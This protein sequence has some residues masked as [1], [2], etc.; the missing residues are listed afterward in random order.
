V[1]NTHRA[2]LPAGVEELA[3][4]TLV[5]NAV[6]ESEVSVDVDEAQLE[7]R[8]LE[9]E[10]QGKLAAVAL[11]KLTLSS[12]NLERGREVRTAFENA[13]PDADVAERLLEELTASE[14]PVAMQLQDI[15][16]SLVVMLTKA[17]LDPEAAAH[18][19]KL[20]RE[21]MGLSGAIRTRMTNSLGAVANLRA[22]RKFLANHRGR[23]G[24]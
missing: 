14:V 18:I 4:T 16:A 20:L 9:K 23:V 21:T 19:A 22:Q 24:V 10:E 12:V 11:S 5:D 2:H 6:L 3:S 8:R 7:L 15:E 13:G 1:S 17:I